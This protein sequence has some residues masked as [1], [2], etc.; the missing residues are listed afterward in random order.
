[1]GKQYCMNCFRK[2]GVSPCPCCGY[3][4]EAKDRQAMTGAILAGRYLVG[5]TLNRTGLE[6][7]YK[8]WDLTRRRGVQI[9][10]YFPVGYAFRGTEGQVLWQQD[11]I[12]EAGMDAFL[13]GAVET[14]PE[15]VVADSFIANGTAYILRRRKPAPETPEIPDN[16]WVPFLMALAAVLFCIVMAVPIF[17]TESIPEETVPQETYVQE[18]DENGILRT[19]IYRNEDGTPVSVL[20]YDTNARLTRRDFYAD[21]VLSA[22]EE[23]I[24]DSEGNYLETVIHGVSGE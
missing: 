8:G 7:T 4:P 22:W 3:A 21:G 9:Q 13:Q 18:L 1:M 5:R 14:E 6:Y 15:T 11:A 12:R 10:E 17:R 20:H 24:C 19:E 23:I 2:I 16:P